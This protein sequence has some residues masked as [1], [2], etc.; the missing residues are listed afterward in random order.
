MADI[1][2]KFDELRTAK[3]QLDD[4]IDEFDKAK[5]N[6]DDLEEAIGDPFGK[7]N[8]RENVE[9]F[10]DRWDSKRDNLNESLKAVRDH[11]AGVIDGVTDWDSETAAKL[12]PPPKPVH[13]N[14][15]Y[16]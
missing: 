9:D 15:T 1:Y 3:G 14:M 5:D 12:A 16:V 6:A 7:N 4:I 10:E 8:L 13:S 2:I 11:I